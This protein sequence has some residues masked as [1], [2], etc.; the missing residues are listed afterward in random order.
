MA[1]PRILVNDAVSAP[2]VSKKRSLDPQ[3]RGMSPAM[4]DNDMSPSTQKRPH[5][6]GTVEAA[7]P[8]GGS[9]DT[10]P[11]TPRR[12]TSAATTTPPTFAVDADGKRIVVCPLVGFASIIHAFVLLCLLPACFTAFQICFASLRVTLVFPISAVGSW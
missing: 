9:S 4:L 2:V 1:T 3:S 11:L 10:I 12:S 6:E 5:I 7:N 8:T